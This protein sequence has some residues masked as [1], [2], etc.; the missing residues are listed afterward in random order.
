VLLRHAC[1]VPCCEIAADLGVSESR[2]SQ[3]LAMARRRVR[4]E[5]GLLSD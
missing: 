1:G 2:V 5:A 4:V 3:L